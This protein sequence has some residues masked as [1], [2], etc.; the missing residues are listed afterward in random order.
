MEGIGQ[1]RDLELLKWFRSD[2]QDGQRGSHLE[3]LQLTS[4][5]NGKSD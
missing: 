4:A 5:P 1:H 3:N 2:I